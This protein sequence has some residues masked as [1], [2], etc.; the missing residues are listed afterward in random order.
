MDVRDL[1]FADFA[2]C[3]HS[4]FII[5]V[6]GYE[7]LPLEL[8]DATEGHSAPRQEQF[9]LTFHNAAGAYIPQ[10][11]YQL[12]HDKL[13]KIDLFLVPIGPREGNGMNYQAV[14]NRFRS[15]GGSAA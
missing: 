9:S 7:P 13:G 6:P 2:A 5:E 11:I 8:T 3:L 4:T 15:Q 14:F 10:A 12:S 1:H